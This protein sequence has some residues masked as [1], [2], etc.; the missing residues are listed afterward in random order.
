MSMKKP[1]KERL[2]EVQA[3]HSMVHAFTARHESVLDKVIPPEEL[4]ATAQQIASSLPVSVET[5]QPHY[6]HDRDTCECMICTVLR[7]DD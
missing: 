5:K 4:K 3:A 7:Q 2:D 6:T 1:K